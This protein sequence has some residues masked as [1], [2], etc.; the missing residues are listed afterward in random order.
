MENLAVS[1]CFGLLKT[2]KNFCFRKGPEAE[3][4]QSCFSFASVCF[5]PD[6][7]LLQLCFGLLRPARSSRSKPLR[8][9]VGASLVGFASLLQ[10]QK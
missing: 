1:V 3:L 5:R 2:L 10:T 8:V 9:C 7:G 6:F 4:K